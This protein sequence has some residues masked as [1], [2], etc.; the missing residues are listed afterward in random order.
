MSFKEELLSLIKSYSEVYS[1]VTVVIL[2]AYII[3]YTD[4]YFNL[5]EKTESNKK[6]LLERI[7]GDCFKKQIQATLII[8][9]CMILSFS[10]EFFFK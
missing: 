8:I 2:V 7:G 10:Y 6:R 1:I 9:A 3:S 4:Q 5:I